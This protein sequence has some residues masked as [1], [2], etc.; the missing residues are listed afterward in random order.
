MGSGKGRMGFILDG[1]RGSRF[2]NI[3]GNTIFALSSAHF[4]ELVQICKNTIHK[5]TSSLKKK[6]GFK[7]YLCSG[8]AFPHFKMTFTGFKG[9]MLLKW[10]LNQEME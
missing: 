4:L 5:C 9:G 8:G 3:G 6:Y 1:T 7:F 2:K 10:N